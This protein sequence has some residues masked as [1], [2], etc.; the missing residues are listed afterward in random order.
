MVVR[1]EGLSEGQVARCYEALTARF[2]DAMRRVKALDLDDA[3]LGGGFD[4]IK[5]RHHGRYDVTVPEF[6]ERPF[7]FTRDAA[8]WMGLV[9]AALGADAKL[10]HCGCMLSLPD[11]SVQPWHSDGDHLSETRHFSPHCVNVF[12]PLVELTSNNGPTEFVPGSHVNGKWKG[13]AHSVTPCVP[14][15]SYL[16]FDY[17]LRHRGLANHS[18]QPRPLLYLTY[19]KPFFADATNFSATRYPEL[20]EV[21]EW[22]GGDERSRKR[23]QLSEKERRRPSAASPKAALPPGSDEQ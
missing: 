23:E 19:A 18:S 4:A 16:V 17:R 11:S 5:L 10:V 15:G 12:V 20:P 14:A 3:L 9:R 2:E 1:T 21:A 13:A 7:R 8:P 6:T 22:Q